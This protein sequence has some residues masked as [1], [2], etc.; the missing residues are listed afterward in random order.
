MLLGVGVADKEEFKYDRYDLAVPT[1]FFS[2]LV[3]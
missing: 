3:T 1:L 2:T